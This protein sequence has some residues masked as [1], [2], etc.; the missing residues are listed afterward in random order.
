LRLEHI[1][2]HSG[3]LLHP[4]LGLV[5]VLAFWTEEAWQDLATGEHLDIALGN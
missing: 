5:V 2:G 3:T 1:L 4:E